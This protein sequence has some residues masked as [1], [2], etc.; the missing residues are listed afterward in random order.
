MKDDKPSANAK[1][2][3]WV[4]VLLG[5]AFLIAAIMSLIIKTEDASAK[6]AAF[7]FAELGLLGLAITVISISMEAILNSLSR[8]EEKT[9]GEP[10]DDD[11]ID[12]MA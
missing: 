2:I 1:T 5:V 8:I 9:S 6:E 12:I 7:R 4:G 11:D 10:E 3:K